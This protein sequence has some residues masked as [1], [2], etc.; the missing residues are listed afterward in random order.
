MQSRAASRY[1]KSLIELSLEKGE[2]EKV[3]ADMKLIQSVCHD[4]REFTTL[5]QSPVVKAD[6]K[7]KILKAIFADKVSAI[8]INFLIVIAHKRRE[9]IINDVATSFIDQYYAHKNVLRTVIRSVNGVGE[10]VKKK[11]SE[12]VKKTYNSEVEIIEEHDAKLIGG[13]V[14]KVGDKQL[15]ASIKTKLEKLRR[16]FSDNPYIADF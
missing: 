10:N 11:V 2:L 12:I 13:F 6:A 14:L 1:A 4:S 3:F 8:S 7:E 9:A 16:N 5:L 15:D